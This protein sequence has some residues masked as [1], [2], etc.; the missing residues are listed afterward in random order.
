MCNKNKGADQLCSFCTA[1]LHLC[2]CI[3]KNV[4]NT[5]SEISR[6]LGLEIE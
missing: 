1:D 4:K 2:F 3:C 5:S 6:T